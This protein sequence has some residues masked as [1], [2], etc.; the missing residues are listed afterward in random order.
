MTRFTRP[1]KPSKL[2]SPACP[3]QPWHVIIPGMPDRAVTASRWVM[4]RPAATRP[5]RTTRIQ[6]VMTTRNCPQPQSEDFRRCNHVEHSRHVTL[7]SW[8]TAD[9]FQLDEGEILEGEVAHQATQ[10][11]KPVRELPGQVLRRWLVIGALVPDLQGGGNA[12]RP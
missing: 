4:G 11:E 3:E 12:E 7:C 2:M 8:R 5:S 9:L 6:P 10:P 1:L